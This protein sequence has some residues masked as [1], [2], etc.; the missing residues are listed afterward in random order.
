ME[1]FEVRE[2]TAGLLAAVNELLPQLSEAVRP[3]RA[4]D[5]EGVVAAEA[6]RLFMAREQE[7]YY[8]MLTLICFAAPT[9]RWARIEDLV[10]DGQARGKGLGR[11]LV[12][13]AIDAAAAWGAR[14]VDLTSNPTRL[15]A[16]RLYQ[17]MGFETRTTHVYRLSLSR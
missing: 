9:G 4:A 3:M 2:V 11:R 5:L 14:A 12:A 7:K 13:H 16:N 17:Q 10:V 6:S 8:G 15:A 1:I